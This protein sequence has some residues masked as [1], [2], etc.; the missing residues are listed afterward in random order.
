MHFAATSKAITE[1]PTLASSV[2][3]KEKTLM[4]KKKLEI[5][6]HHQIPPTKT[7]I[8]LTVIVTISPHGAEEKK[9]NTRQL[10]IRKVAHTSLANMQWTIHQHVHRIS[11]MMTR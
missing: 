6:G 5:E 2:E 4:L 1:G 9:E 7:R 8:N 11:P 3:K 10:T